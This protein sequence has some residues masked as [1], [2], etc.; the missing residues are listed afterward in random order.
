MSKRY[1]DHSGS[2]TI[3][4][5]FVIFQTKNLVCD[6]EE[7]PIYMDAFDRVIFDLYGLEDFSRRM[8]R[9]RSN[10]TTKE[11]IDRIGLEQLVNL[12]KNPIYC[13]ILRDLMNVVNDVNKIAKKIKKNRN[14]GESTKKYV[15]L[16]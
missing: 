8:S 11:L 12:L 15:K 14:K 9:C 5:K 3:L 7:Y 1:N 4:Y 6:A 10:R 16:N 13:N 2:K